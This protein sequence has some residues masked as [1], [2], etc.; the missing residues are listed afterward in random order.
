MMR[1]VFMGTP[2]FAV[3]SLRAILDAGHDVPLVVTTPDRQKGRGLRT[4][5]SDV[6]RFSSE[7]GLEIAKPETLKD[8]SLAELIRSKEPDVICVVAFRILPE[9]I[10]TIPSR[11]SFNLHA[12]LLPKYRGAAP[13]NW[14]LINGETESGVTTFFLQRKVDTGSMIL[15]RRVPIGPETTAGELHDA[16]MRVGADAVVET[17]RLIETGEVQPQSQDDTQ[18]T[19][20]PKIFRDDCRIDWSLP[21]RRV[22][23]FIRGLSPHPGA[24]THRGD[25][26]VKVLRSRQAG[27]DVD[28]GMLAPGALA[29]DGRRLHVRC[30]DGLLEIVELQPEGRRA[31]SAEEYLRGRPVGAGER[32]L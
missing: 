5:P 6:S 26:M 2:E 27:E 10:Y 23:D 3:E 21:A 24:F 1:V 22:H 29:S 18:A 20:A 32:F 19:P 17:L 25:T 31:M 12:S 15:Q 14:A 28:G 8:P 30:S 7:R 4:I 11:G 9:S 16:L 13:I